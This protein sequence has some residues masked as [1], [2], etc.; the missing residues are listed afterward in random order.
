MRTIIDVHTRADILLFNFSFNSKFVIISEISYANIVFIL[1]TFCSNSIIPIPCQKSIH[2]Q[3][4][5][6]PV[7]SRVA[8]FFHSFHAC[9][10]ITHISTKAFSNLKINYPDLES[11]TSIWSKKP[12]PPTNIAAT[13]S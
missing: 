11:Q 6:N 4:L 10:K 8:F 3:E 12:N 5:P 1:P 2:Q 9:N 7:G 13:D